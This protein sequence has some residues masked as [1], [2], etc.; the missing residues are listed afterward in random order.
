MKAFL[1]R[2]AVIALALCALTA[3]HAEAYPIL[4]P[5]VFRDAKCLEPTKFDAQPTFATFSIG[6]FEA[7]TAEVAE[8]KTLLRALCIRDAAIGPDE[9]KAA[10][11]VEHIRRETVAAD[12]TYKAHQQSDGSLLIT[13][14]GPWLAGGNRFLAFRLTLA[15]GAAVARV[16]V[17]PVGD[18]IEGLT[19]GSSFLAQEEYEIVSDSICLN[20]VRFPE[21]PTV[22]R[23]SEAPYQ[24]ILAYTR[25]SQ[26]AFSAMCVQGPSFDT[27]EVREFLTS[28]L[29]AQ[30]VKEA[31]ITESRDGDHIMAHAHGYQEN[32]GTRRRFE[33]M[34]R[35]DRV[36]ITAR[37][38]AYVQTDEL[39]RRAADFLG[40][41]SPTPPS[42][43]LLTFDN[44]ACFGPIRFPRT[45]EIKLSPDGQSA[46]LTHF[47]RQFLANCYVLPSP[48]KAEALA[49]GLA[50]DIVQ[51]TVEKDYVMAIEKRG[52]QVIVRASGTFEQSGQNRREA[53][54]TV[55]SRKMQ[56]LVTTI[57]LED[58]PNAESLAFLRQQV[59]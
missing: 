23:A 26:W 3:P 49:R 45:P 50:E 13:G 2:G 18:I 4:N 58:N 27:S 51:S 34:V 10:G 21:A 32:N 46:V 47:D 59:D 38:A 30:K 39:T 15:K 37:F 52:D 1:G 42:E 33:V 16:A 19:R 48:A 43:T 57:P 22:E 54:I 56:M 41:T 5:I 35:H 25:S 17:T 20:P 29:E 36:R 14:S 40:L 31:R 55:T 12:F 11:I 24:R 53:V 7:A 9:A 8:G 6:P 28:N 44:K